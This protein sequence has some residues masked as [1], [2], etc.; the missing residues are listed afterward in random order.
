MQFR[1]HY[2]VENERRTAEVEAGSPAEAVVKFRHTRSGDQDHRPRR[3][4][5][6]SVLP[7]EVPV[8]HQ[9]PLVRDWESL[10]IGDKLPW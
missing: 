8:P 2:L 6:L 7:V 4:H 10:T 3:W 5:I 1:V 9:R